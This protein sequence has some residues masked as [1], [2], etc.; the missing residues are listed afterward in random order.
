V[1][2]GCPPFLKRKSTPHKEIVDKKGDWR[3]EK[4]CSLIKLVKGETKVE[5][6]EQIV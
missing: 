3:G 1:G 6:L 5:F 2:G 4:G